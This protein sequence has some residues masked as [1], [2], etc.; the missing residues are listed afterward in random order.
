MSMHELAISS[1]VYTIFA[2]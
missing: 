2:K 1:L